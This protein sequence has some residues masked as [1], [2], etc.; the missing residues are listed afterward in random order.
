MFSAVRKEITV[1]RRVTDRKSW[2][3]Q[4]LL[5]EFCV[6]CCCCD[7]GECWEYTCKK[8]SSSVEISGIVSVLRYQKDCSPEGAWKPRQ[9][10]S[11]SC[12]TEHCRHTKR[13]YVVLTETYWCSLIFC[14]AD[15]SLK[16]LDIVLGGKEERVCSKLKCFIDYVI[17]FIMAFRD[18]IRL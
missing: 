18:P 2:S 15:N 6:V 1:E 11:S 4:P 7:K 12:V 10:L 5:W 8:M 3:A 14:S 9:S 13:I 17:S 16:H